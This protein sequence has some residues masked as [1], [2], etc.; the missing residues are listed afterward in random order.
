MFHL[1][2]LSYVGRARVN[3]SVFSLVLKV[4]RVL[5]VLM[6]TVSWFQTVGAATEKAREETEVDA[7]G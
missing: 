3:S 6:F 1:P 2:H 7:Y 5:A 4:P